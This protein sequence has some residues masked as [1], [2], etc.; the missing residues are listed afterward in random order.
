MDKFNQPI[1]MKKNI[2]TEFDN[3]HGNIPPDNLL[4]NEN[5]PMISDEDFDDY[6]L[7]IGPFVTKLTKRTPMNAM[8]Q[9]ILNRNPTS[10]FFS[11][12]YNVLLGFNFTPFP[13]IE[14][15]SDAIHIFTQFIINVLTIYFGKSLEYFREPQITLHKM[16]TA[17]ISS[18]LP[19]IKQLQEYNQL[20]NYERNNNNNNIISNSDLQNDTS[21]IDRE[22]IEKINRLNDQIK[23]TR[24][25]I[26]DIHNI[27][28][29]I[30][31]QFLET[32][33]T[34]YNRQNNILYN[35]PLI[36]IFDTP[37]EDS[38]WW[39]S[40][41]G[42][43]LWLFVHIISGSCKDAANILLLDGI[44]QSLQFFIGCGECYEHYLQRGIPFLKSLINQGLA[45]DRQMIVLH[46]YVF[47]DSIRELHSN[48]FRDYKHKNLFQI[49]TMDTIY[50]NKYMLNDYY[51]RG[52]QID[53]RVFWDQIQN[54]RDSKT[55]KDRQKSQEK[56]IKNLHEL[57]SF[58]NKIPK[59]IDAL[60]NY[61]NKK[62][63]LNRTNG[64]GGSDDD[65][66][67]IMIE[68][69]DMALTKQYMRNVHGNMSQITL[70]SL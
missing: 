19:L 14:D 35:D 7:N 66:G 45:I 17:F 52:L 50:P 15:Y 2:L 24:K 18:L 42:T 21:D 37:I 53:Y 25:N 41:Y 61:N 3:Y 39:G 60:N 68:L 12:F 26:Q 10:A 57:V 46:Q 11:L 32:Q 58:H 8:R 63:S 31:L 64:G 62:S 34:T 30:L 33:N 1:E 28:N 16:M 13:K 22:R 67:N 40:L 49:Y 48:Y 44:V 29:N 59:T 56:Y 51:I 23:D 38:D 27:R 6:I 65:A 43:N 69:Y 47:M 54:L 70:S 5:A 36:I 9:S 55:I 4:K 20:L